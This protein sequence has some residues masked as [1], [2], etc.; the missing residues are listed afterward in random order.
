MTK[1]CILGNGLTS[2][3]LAKFLVNKGIYV[4]IY[5]TRKNS[6]QD[7]S[8]TIGISKKNLDFF[9]KEILNINK[10][11]WNIN[12]IQIYS[13]NLKNEKILSF[14]NKN[15]TLFAIFRNHQLYKHLLLSLKKNKYCKF[16]DNHKLKEFEIKR[17]NLV[18]NSDEKNNISKKYFFK[19]IKKKYNSY[20]YT[21][22]I[23]HKKIDNNSAYQIFTKNGPM[24]FL[25]LSN[26]ETSIVYSIK[27]NQNINLRDLV[28]KYNFKYSITKFGNTSFFNLKSVNLRSYYYKNILAF[29][30]LLHKIHPLAG[31]GFN[32]SLRDI[33]D[34]SDIIKFKFDH[35]LELDSSICQDFENKTKHKNFIFSTGIDFLYEFFNLESKTNSSLLSKS[36]KLIGKNKFINRSFEKIA[37]NG[38]NI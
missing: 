4:D 2:L 29:G 31:Q 5:S 15:D 10:F 35:G 24:A 34:F 26:T 6:D 13:D 28:K 8:R 21:T 38:L 12:K 20:A 25:P 30:D 3:S 36:L 19:K 7:K 22:I 17:Y 37:N 16:K 23:K 32:M 11:L 18:I 9:N 27:G 1:L 33:K 14:K